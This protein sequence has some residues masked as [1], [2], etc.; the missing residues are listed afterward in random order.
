MNSY[1]MFNFGSA[2]PGPWQIALCDGSVQAI[3]Y[4]IDPQVHHN[5]GNRADGKIAVLP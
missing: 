3:G 5:F 4:W 1:K 2:H